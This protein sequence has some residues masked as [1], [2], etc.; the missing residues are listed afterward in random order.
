MGEKLVLAY[1]GG[2]D[3][4]VSIAWLKENYETS[5]KAVSFLRY[6]DHGFDQAPYEEITKEQY[7]QMISG[8]Q[9]LTP[10][11]KYLEVSGEDCSTGSCPIR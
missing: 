6:N 2:L 7:E 8:I 10:F 9:E 4:S 11:N 3:T 5:I 1:S